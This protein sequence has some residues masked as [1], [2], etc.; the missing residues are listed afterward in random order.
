ML[1]HS[2]SSWKK[3]EGCIFNFIVLI[4]SSSSTIET[5]TLTIRGVVYDESYFSNVTIEIDICC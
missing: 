5:V 3:F 2:L 4:I 1:P